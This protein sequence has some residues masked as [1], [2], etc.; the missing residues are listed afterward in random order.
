MTEKQNDQQSMDAVGSELSGGLDRLR[1]FAVYDG[2]EC[3]WAITDGPEKARA[4]SREYLRD[5]AHPEDYEGE[6]EEITEMKMDAKLSL[7][8]DENHISDGGSKITRTCAEWI[9]D[10]GD[11]FLATT[12]I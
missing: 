3:V 5:S 6:D 7:W 9:K 2:G 8:W 12:C 11:G 1:V 10:Q 4:I